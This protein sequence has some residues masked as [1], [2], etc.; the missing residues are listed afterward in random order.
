[1]PP[2]STKKLSKGKE[3]KLKRKQEQAEVALSLEKVQ[4][5]YQLGDYM[6][7]FVPFR[8]FSR[9]GI[10]ATISFNSPELLKEHDIKEMFDILKDNMKS[11]YI[12][13]GWGW[14]DPDKLDELT[15]PSSRYL[16]A[17]DSNAQKLLGFISF[18]FDLD[19][20]IEVLYW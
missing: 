13:G 16:L 3:K 4:S 19:Q 5:A 1:M 11:L 2:K 14:N 17:R 6:D 10:A 12:S 20:D 9:N 15:H 18:R 7:Y 8:N